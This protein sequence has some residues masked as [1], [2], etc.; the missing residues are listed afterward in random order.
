MNS[1]SADRFPPYSYV[2]GRFPHPHSHPQGHSYEHEPPPVAEG[3]EPAIRERFAWGVELFN[4]G[5][6][7]ESHEAWES[8][9]LAS[10][11]PR[12]KQRIQALI[13]L[14]AAA[15]KGREMRSEGVR[16]HLER[17]AELLGEDVD[18]W[19]GL[20]WKQ[21]VIDLQALRQN[22]ACLLSD[23]N[24]PVVKTVPFQLQRSA[25]N[26]SAV[27]AHRERR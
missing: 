4:H 6:Y 15:V 13:K 2:S 19:L 26:E 3:D 11:E 23:S 17:A 25:D 9:W 12:L 7:W 20:D 8:I 27:Q 10:S 16:R 1:S 21:L 24:D 18:S 5:Y 22:P 14:A